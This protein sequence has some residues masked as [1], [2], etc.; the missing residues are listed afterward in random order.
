MNPFFQSVVCTVFSEQV[1]LHEQMFV[2][3]VKP[4]LSVF[5]LMCIVFCTLPKKTIAC[6]CFCSFVYDPSLT[7]CVWCELRAEVHSF[8]LHLFI[9]LFNYLLEKNF[10]FLLNRLITLV[11][12][13]LTMVHRS[14]D[15]LN[16]L[17]KQ[18]ILCYVNLTSIL[19]NQSTT[20]MCSWASVLLH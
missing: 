8:F 12:N 10:L 18:S 7:F 15:V 9:C 19:K 1:S 11:K 13:Q 14:M 4:N 17:G 6:F 3:L 5:P 16:T 2:I 20:C